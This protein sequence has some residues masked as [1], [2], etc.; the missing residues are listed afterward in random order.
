MG[1]GQFGR[2]FGGFVACLLAGGGAGL[3]EPAGK[4]SEPYVRIY[5][6]THEYSGGR[7]CRLICGG[8]FV[9]RA[10][11]EQIALQTHPAVPS[12]WI[13]AGYALRAGESLETH[14]GLGKR[15]RS[16]QCLF[17]ALI[18]PGT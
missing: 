14:G 18:Q 3:Q 6:Q 10:T 7:N 16:T 17:A 9:P 2:L 11:L 8:G 5:C 13:P 1:D 12:E 15:H 4:A